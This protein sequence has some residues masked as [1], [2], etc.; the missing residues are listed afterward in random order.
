MGP[1]PLFERVAFVGGPGGQEEVEGASEAVDV[2]PLVHGL[3]IVGPFGRNIVDRS[4]H[5]AAL[6]QGLGLDPRPAERVF[7]PRQP[8]VQHLD[9]PV[10]VQQKIGRLDVQVNDVHRMGIFQSLGGLK[11]VLNSRGH[12]QRPLLF[13][14]SH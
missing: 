6:D 13:D 1:D 10:P 14:Q 2:G 12:R 8:H 11:D 4:H 3:G 9:R 5:F 7:D